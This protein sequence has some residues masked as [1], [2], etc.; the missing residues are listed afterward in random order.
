MPSG[1]E[2]SSGSLLTVSFQEEVDHD[3]F[4]AEIADMG[5]PDAIIQETQPTGSFIIRTH[6]LSE[7]ESDQIENGL[8]AAFGEFAAEP[9]IQDVSPMVA[10]ETRTSAIWASG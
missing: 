10:S 8:V 1:I 2:F 9:S 6:R 7:V 3:E 5:Y 4:V